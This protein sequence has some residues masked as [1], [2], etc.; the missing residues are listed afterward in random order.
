MIVECPICESSVNATVLATHV[1]GNIDLY[2]APYQ[3]QR[4]AVRRPV[5]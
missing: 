1:S 3:P 2:G 5:H 4:R